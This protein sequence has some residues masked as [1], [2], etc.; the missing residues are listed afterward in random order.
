VAGTRKTILL[1]STLNPYPFWAGS[2][3]YWFDFVRDERV[4][5]EL[6]FHAVLADSPT[7]R[8]R[9]AE[10]ETTGTQISFYKH[11]NVNFIP[12][13]LHRLSDR[14]RNRER[15]TL[16]WYDKILV[17]NADLV[18][19]NVAQLAD[20]TDLAYAVSLCRQK[21]VPYYIILQ[22]ANE[23][24]CLTSAEQLTAVRDVAAG[25]QRFVFI[26]KRNREV[27]E[28]ALAMKLENAFHSTNALPTSRLEEASRAA[29]GSQV[30]ANGTAKFIS[31]GRFSPADKGQHLL[32]QAM[33]E[34]EWGD[35]DWRLTFTGM[36]DYGKEYLSELARF[37]K[38]AEG[39]IFFDA[40]TDNVFEAICEND[41]LIMPSLTEGLPYAMIEAMACAR[42]AV[43]TPVAGIPELIREGMTGW[44]SSDATVREISQ[45]L[46][47]CWKDRERWRD[48]GVNAQRLVC[49]N[50]NESTTHPE[51]LAVI[52][53]D[54]TR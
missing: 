37:H 18:W 19:F 4:R 52:A 49:K 38:I 48:Y 29:A 24:F 50:N 34:S 22:A 43:G 54:L 27:L 44:L 21:H 32:V 9:A 30:S 31:L 8:A 47:R 39:R 5:T 2:E 16:P 7:T 33:A 40:F 35:R 23:N 53:S 14:L 28:N 46:D 20:L 42:P 41:V 6:S 15:R 10:L 17:E 26:A 13:N 51:L 3:T 1:F 11:F 12:R 36:S 45:A 25:A